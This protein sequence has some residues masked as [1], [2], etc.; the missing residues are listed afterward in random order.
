MDQVE[1]KGTLELALEVSNIGIWEY[2]PE[3]GQT[4]FNR[5]WYELIE[6]SDNELP[7]TNEVFFNLLHPDD[8]KKVETLTQ[9]LSGQKEEDRYELNFRMKT[10]S[11]HW[12]WICCR[13]FI[14]ERDEFGNVIH[15]I[16]THTDIDGLKKNE[17]KLLLQKEN[18]R[19]NEESLNA[20][21]NSLNDIIY[22]IDKNYNFRNIWVKDPE[23]YTIDIDFLIG[24]DIS[25]QF[26]PRI[27]KLLKSTIDE[28]IA[29]RKTIHHEHY[30]SKD[31]KWFASSTSYIHDSPNRS[32]KVSV[33][34]SDITIRKKSEQKLIENEELLEAIFESA[35]HALFLIDIHEFKIKRFNNSAI[36]ILAPESPGELFNQN[37]FEFSKNQYSREKVR[38]IRQKLESPGYWHEE[39]IFL[40]DNG[41]EFWADLKLTQLE[42]H[43]NEFLVASIDNITRRKENEALIIQNE[44]NQSII[45]YFTTSIYN[46]NTVE[47]ILW[48]ITDNCIQ[49][50]GF[51]DCIIYMYAPQNNMLE[52]KAY[53]GKYDRVSGIRNTR[54]TL[55]MGEGIVGQVAIDKEPVLDNNV[56]LNPNYIVVDPNTESEL[57]VPILYNNELIGVI[58]SESNEKNFYTENDL[59]VLSSIAAIA[60]NKIIKAIT[61]E[62]IVKNEANLNALINN[63]RDLIWSIDQSGRLSSYNRAFRDFVKEYSGIV[64]REGILLNKKNSKFHMMTDWVNFYEI[65]LNGEQFSEVINVK[66]PNGEE[67]FFD[68]SFNPIKTESNR[69]IGLSIISRD[70]TELIKTKKAAEQASKLKAEFLS[71]M[72]HEIRTPLN[73]VIGMAHLLME[74]NPSDSQLQYINTLQLSANNLLS[75]INDILDFNK[76]EA[77]KIEMEKSEFNL[78][79]LVRNTTKSLEMK[80][81]EKGLLFHLEVD[82]KIPELVKGDPTRINQ[83]LINLLSNA[84]K[85]TEKGH[86]TTRLTLQG[87]SQNKASI[88]FEVTDTG[89]GIKK[90]NHSIIFDQFTQANNETTRLYGGTGLGLSITRKLLQLM[91]SDI[92]LRS[93]LGEGSCFYFQ[94]DLDT[95]NSTV[96]MEQLPKS[97][98]HN[99]PTVTSFD[100]KSILIVED[101]EINAFLVSKFI[102]KWGMNYQIVENGK[103]AVNAVEENN[104][105]LILM[106][107]QMPE[108]NGFEATSIIRGLKDIRK[109]ETPIV[110]LTAQAQSDIKSRVFKTGFNDFIPKPFDPDNLYEKILQLVD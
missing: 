11:G 73:A 91:N 1:E 21:L 51:L 26:T 92:H 4:K 66:M 69:T 31:N 88:L 36:E 17:E 19:N 81:L 47:D 82:Q 86:V 54:K 99:I 105:D 98:E 20:L 75:L 109:A 15:W 52:L 58:D 60:A 13:A 110:A 100:K 43:E 72:S 93:E 49:Q 107:L 97:L 94:L 76:I 8:Q 40:T 59:K 90:E 16:G 48:D 64:V 83:I 71:T 61:E 14:A 65:G 77:Q 38:L 2:F 34:I 27:A 35:N 70:I 25:H 108:M 46:K 18:I 104:F 44:I 50:L 32:E 12:K 62:R 37:L 57:T 24:K 85:F 68:T 63:T 10:K 106:D 6:Y 89:I 41:S 80:A 30:S 28:V 53:S 78:S 55:R 42:N 95:S 29:T 56:K 96:M 67:R 23:E 102:K 101:N 33:L 87:I 39:T 45:T 9:L 5:Q 74:E 79:E 7:Q 3:T 103:Q 84:I 22:I